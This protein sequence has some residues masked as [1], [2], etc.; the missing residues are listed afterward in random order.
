MIN[1]REQEPPLGAQRRHLRI[2]TAP[3]AAAGLI[4]GY[5]IAMATGSRPLG[6]V[7]LAGFALVCLAIWLRRDGR[8]T[9]GV[10]TVAGLLA[11][12]LS[13]VLALIVGAWPAVLITAAALAA[14]CWQISDARALAAAHARP[15]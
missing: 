12:A 14:L 6:G 7:V 3:I 11:F 10:L 2:A 1:Q 8:R 15:A 13:H 9:A 4:A 5:G